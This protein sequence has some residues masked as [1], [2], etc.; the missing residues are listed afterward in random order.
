MRTLP[1]ILLAII[2]SLLAVPSPALADLINPNPAECGCV[3]VTIN[4][5]TMPTKPAVEPISIEKDKN[6]DYP[7][8]LSAV[9]SSR[10]E[11]ANFSITSIVLA[12][13]GA[14]GG[15]STVP[16]TLPNSSSF[17]GTVKVHG[18][19][20]LISF[21]KKWK[22]V[23][24]LS[25]PSNAAVICNY[26]FILGG[27]CKACSSGVC[28]PETKNESGGSST[29][30]PMPADAGDSNGS[31]GFNTLDLSNP[32][33]AGV[34]ASVPPSFTVNRTSG[35]INSVVSPV[36]TVEVTPISGHA[37]DPNAFTITHKHTVT[38]V[39]FRTTTVAQVD[40]YLT[41][42]STFDSTTFRT[43]QSNPVV[44]T[45]LLESGPVV[46]GDF[47]VLR[48][49][50]LTI[51]A[52][53][54]GT[55]IHRESV[56]ERP[57]GTA[58]FA[59]VSDIQST[60]N[61]YAWGWE[62]TEQIID[63]GDAPHAN[64]ISTWSYYQPTEV[65][66]PYS[67]FDGEGR[68]KSHSRYDGHEEAH[69]YW[70]NNH[71]VKLPFA[72][73][74]EGLILSQV[75]NPANF[76]LTTIRKV[77]TNTLSKQTE[78]YI[79]A[80]NTRT[81]STF[82]DNNTTLTTTTVLKPFGADFGGQ[83]A[84]ISHPD[85]TL[86]TYEY[87]RY[88]DG[89][90][91]VVMKTGSP[92]G[93]AV[94]LGQQTTA[95]YN[96]NGTAIRSLSETIGY[97][98]N[99]IIDHTA[100][101]LVDDYGR[102]RTN[103]YFPSGS[104]ATDGAVQASA[105]APKWTTTTT[106]SCCGV[107][108]TTDR[109]GI[110]T[111]YGY[112]GLRRQTK[113][114]TLGV[115]TETVR[116]GLT[117]DTHRY[118]TGPAATGN[119]ISSDSRNL[120]GTSTTSSS[121]DPSPTNPNPGDLITASSTVTTYKPTTVLAS[122]TVTTVPGDFIQTTDTYL[123]GR[124][125]STTGDLQPA[126]THTYSVNGTGLVTTS[127]YAGGNEST[128]VTADWAGRTYTT[129][130]DSATTTQTYN[131]LGQ[132]SS[133][134]DADGVKT[135][136]AY[137]SL[138][139]RTTTALDVDS[140]GVIDYNGTSATPVEDQVT[141]TE[142]VP[143]TYTIGGTTYNVMKTTT[144]VYTA[145]NAADT[146][147]VST[148]YQTPDGLRSWATSDA[149]ASPSR[150][151]INPVTWTQTATNPDG[152]YSE[153]TIN[154]D[155]LTA[156]TIQYSSDNNLIVQFDYAYDT[157][158]RLRTTT[159]SRTGTTTTA[160]V[161]TTC[162][163]VRSVTDPGSRVT[164]FAYDSRGRRVSTTL[165]DASVTHSSYYP[166]GQLKA[167][168]GSQ[169]YPTFITYDYAGR[170]KTLRTQ[171]TFINNVPTDAGGSLTTW[172]YSSATGRLTEKVDASNKS[173][174]Y[175]YTDAGRLETR[176]W[177]RG[178]SA[179]YTYS[180][181]RLTATDYSGTT[182]DVTVTYNRVGQPLTIS[183]LV[184]IDTDTYNQSQIQYT[185]ADD[186]SLDTETIKYDLDYN[187]SDEL[188]RTIDR[189]DDPDTGRST[190][191]QL[192]NGNTIEHRADYTYDDAGRL[193]TVADTSNTFTYGYKYSQTNATDPRVGSATGNKQDYMP[194][195]LAS[196][197]G[198]NTTPTLATIR[199][200]EATRN[201]L[202]KIE[203]FAENNSI[204]RYTYTVNSIGQRSALST[205]FNLGSGIGN[206][207]GSTTWG[208]DSL[209]QLTSADAPNAFSVDRFYAYDAIGN[210]LRS[211][212]GIAS[213]D[214]T[215]TLT[216]YFGAASPS[217]VA[218][219]NILNQYARIKNGS[220]TVSPNYDDD[221]NATAYP[222]PALVTANSSLS[223]DA[224]N[225]LKQVTV[226]S[227]ATTYLYDALSRRIAK[228]PASGSPT[229]YVYDG[230]NC[231][232]E[233]TG[234]TPTLSKT[235][236]WGLDLSGSLQGAGGVGG[237]LAEKQ[238]GN[239]FYPTYDGNGNISEY[240]NIDSL[241]VAHYEYDPFGNTVV[242]QG[243][244]AA[245]FNYRFSTKPLDSETGLYYYLYRYYDPLT[246]RWP[247]RDPIEEEGGINLYGFVGNDGTDDIDVLGTIFKHNGVRTIDGFKLVGT[248]GITETKLVLNAICECDSTTKVW[249]TKLAAYWV[250]TWIYISTKTAFS[251][252]SDGKIYLFPRNAH[253][254][255]LTTTHEN[256]H[257]NHYKEWHDESE[258]TIKSDF[259]KS[260][261]T[262]KECDT[263]RVD[264]IRKWMNS[265]A[266]A[267]KNEV[268]HT[269]PVFLTLP[270]VPPMPTP[271]DYSRISY[272]KY[273]DD[274]VHAVFTTNITKSSC[275]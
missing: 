124:T 251:K 257:V 21:T 165:P 203:N 23:V 54:P 195:T 241:I 42:D 131:T 86:T 222:L 272:N 140:D 132:L 268:K 139:E 158:K 192:K 236:T 186:L 26:P 64:L 41:I 225:R 93:G 70:L 48:K 209:G 62:M 38:D 130:Q 60:W 20:P 234:S 142:T 261:A 202:T 30:I 1:T 17:S 22:V 116:N 151:V 161:S 115:T 275:R 59:T 206:N 12:P 259:I 101:T 201:V 98:T 246:G 200:Y 182:P 184:Q 89:G 163:T 27:G 35:V 69:T 36:T 235:R 152:S 84:S 190:G 273:G 228:V 153:T 128:T 127:A 103:A 99:I 83:P 71:E 144:K 245:D 39:V 24:T 214:D 61:N 82:I 224:E 218:G 14:D 160:Y 4:G 156:S 109:Q 258:V 159:D 65:T 266:K 164:T 238:D 262:C 68:L 221:G 94:T 256:A 7:F 244:L 138:G 254:I 55:E 147:T 157:L 204:S 118:T 260:F 250:H 15:T 264:T 211:R 248:L 8:E 92:T 231:I 216:E 72:G 240:L 75:Y 173:V 178:V 74:P 19:N 96:R 217:T 104:S 57:T 106:Y 80:T 43:R 252:N 170:R 32:G 85:G 176:T 133:T 210:R 73:D 107:A 2:T 97:D 239:Y 232:A 114:T 187:G 233:Y 136:Y 90:K 162:D 226:N 81:S 212:M 149:V 230:F 126:M 119:R 177:A 25:T 141:K 199:S 270:G 213:D 208:Y 271:S 198:G 205:V 179:T 34:T 193:G 110:T 134:T 53:Q 47:T 63:P 40:G 155:G 102:A 125:A 37:D 168:W 87:T 146:A 175:F 5:E 188:V 196:T 223:W 16:I 31:V 242:S 79:Q 171:P 113:S 91:N 66:G 253:D 274:P 108:S 88:A 249:R 267:K 56:E 45:S 237:L 243:S 44:G 150:R 180:S 29:D 207:A 121:P 105:T 46:N 215:G 52:P 137:N 247:S 123:D 181:G 122:R 183:Q 166:D 9:V 120:A 219:A 167:T 197:V 49:E 255:A 58:A 112:D 194:Y 227:V 145:F 189:S 78:S 77:G 3:D 191:W 185:Y 269:N 51:T 111:T 135:L 174:G 265:F 148:T 11:C 129:T 50:T 172:N 6:G 33:P 67:A 18:Y 263:Y 10:T 95:T 28:A 169:T 13:V 143:G 229:L 100:V 220:N 154:A 76:T 117:T